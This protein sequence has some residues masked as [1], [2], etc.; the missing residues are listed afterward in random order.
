MGWSMEPRSP[1][2]ADYQFMTSPGAKVEMRLADA[3]DGPELQLFGNRAGLLSLANILLWFTAHAYWREFLPLTE[4]PFVRTEGIL[5]V[6]LHMTAEEPTNRD[7]S[8]VRSDS[9]EQIQWTIS[10]DDLLRVALSVHRL[11]S[12]PGHEYD[13]L[14][15]SERSVAGI[16]I[17]MTDALA[18]IQKGIV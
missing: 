7:G 12:M 9:G 15:L 4:L 14:K 5:S 3:T 11:A 2:E 16:Q 10:E 6:S 17:R 18:W 8:L 13:C 1:D